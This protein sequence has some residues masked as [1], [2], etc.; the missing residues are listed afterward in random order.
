MA[1]FIFLTGGVMSSLGKGILASS[2]GLI[3]K[4]MGYNVSMLKFDPYLNVD[5]GSMNPY[6][7]GEVFVTRDGGEVDLDI[8]HYERF[9]NQN[10]SRYNNI[11]SGYLYKT[12]IEKERKGD[13]LGQ[14]IQVIPHLTQEIINCIKD[15]IKK[16]NCEI[17]ITEIGGT[18]GDIESLPFIEASSELKIEEKDV[19]FF[20]VTYVPYLETTEELKT[21]PTQHSVKELRSLG[22]YPDILFLRSKKDI[23]LQEREKLS[24]YLGIPIEK[25]IP[26]KDLE[27]HYLVPEVLLNS[28]I[29]TILDSIFNEKRDLEIS[30]WL[31]FTSKINKGAKTKK[32]GIL[33]KY[34]E[35]KDAYLSLKE[36]LVHSS[37]ELGIN[38]EIEWISSEDIENLYKNLERVDGIIIPGGFGKR[39]IEGMINGAKY[40][41]ENKKPLLGICL[42]LQI[43]LIEFFRNVIGY[44]EANSTEFEKETPYPVV[45]LLSSQRDIKLLGGTMRL[46]ESE[47]I[48]KENTKAH[49]IYKQTFIKERHRHRYTFNLDFIK[50]LNQGGFI[51][52]GRNKDGEVEIVEYSEH[53]FYIGVQY[54]PE[55]SS[56]PLS[57]NNLFTEFLKIL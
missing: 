49:S 26:V 32:V 46:G 48:I 29:K 37:V 52:S 50:E 20:H 22:V 9:L 1:K 43:I 13:F 35:L 10:L 23:G 44:K 8:G 27:S 14:T 53:P 45:D 30:N 19:F 54:H 42:G 2:L 40:A 33:G 18:V 5:A 12:I 55:F 56:K 17:I 15:V 4:N 34:V 31:N 47:I 24:R 36:A 51:I 7:H 38:V 41:R 21:K 39:G 57:P 16:D 28:N 11:T 3:I 25:I 6:Q